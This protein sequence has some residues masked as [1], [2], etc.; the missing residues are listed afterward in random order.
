MKISDLKKFK[1]KQTMYI[2]SCDLKEITS[3]KAFGSAKDD[4]SLTRYMNNHVK[5]LIK[6]NVEIFKQDRNVVATENGYSI[7]VWENEIKS[8]DEE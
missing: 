4:G 5:E 7:A 3:E 1:T 6:E 8:K 2:V